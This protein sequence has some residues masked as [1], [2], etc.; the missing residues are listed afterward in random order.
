MEITL[1]SK[2]AR[3]LMDHYHLTD[4]NLEFDRSV[5][6]FGITKYN[7]KTIGLSKTLISLNTWDCVKITVLHEIAHALAGSLAG[8]SKF[9]QDICLA[10]GG[11][12]EARYS[13]NFSTTERQVIIPE[14]RYQFI[15]PTHGVISKALRKPRISYMCRR[16][17]TTLAVKDTR[18]GQTINS[19]PVYLY[20]N[21]KRELLSNIKG[22]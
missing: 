4:W 15:C 9:W 13:A 12:G 21:L 5:K 6:R 16:C 7:F 20:G 1:A 8:H 19:R 3:A 11:D 14:Y 17:R 2:L 18:T 10:I 22:A